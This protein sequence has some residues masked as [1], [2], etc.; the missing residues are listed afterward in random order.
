[1]KSECASD[2]VRS[3]NAPYLAFAGEEAEDV[4]FR[5]AQRAVYRSRHHGWRGRGR[6]VEE[7]ARFYREHARFGCMDVR[8]AK[9]VGDARRVKGGGHYHHAQ[10]VA[11][12]APRF[13]GH[14]EGGVALEGSFVELVED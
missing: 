1:M 14:R 5:L 6:F 12:R 10:I 2:S 13:E 11:Q 3:R 7:I 9:V 4:A 8:V